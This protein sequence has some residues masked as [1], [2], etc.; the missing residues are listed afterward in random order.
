MRALSILV[1]TVAA[2]TDYVDGW[3]ARTLRA[4]SKIGVF[5]DPLADKLLTFSGFFALSW[6]RPDIFPWFFLILIMLRD[7][8]MTGLRVYAGR[9]NYDLETSTSAKWKTAVQMIFIYLALISFLLILIRPYRT[10]INEYLF[11]P[12]VM[13]LLYFGV[14]LFTVYTLVEYLFK[15]RKLFSRA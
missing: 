1:Y 7:F 3:L 11:D 14:M 8:S 6:L 9:R 13:T 5:L 2:V 4:N 12:G 10:L 15:N